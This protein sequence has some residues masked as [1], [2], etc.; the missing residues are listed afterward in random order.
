[1][2]KDKLTKEEKDYQKY[3][4]DSIKTI[5]KASEKFNVDPENVAKFLNYLSKKCCIHVWDENNVNFFDSF[6]ASN[7][8]GF[9]IVVGEKEE[10]DQEEEC[11]NETEYGDAYIECQNKMKEQGEN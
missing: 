5:K 9:V 1:M 3:I 8:D 2:T 10:T 7:E 11:D 6:F 4:K